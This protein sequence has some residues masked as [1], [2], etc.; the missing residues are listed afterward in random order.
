[1]RR[2][3][4]ADTAGINVD[5]E[6]LAIDDFRVRADRLDSR[7]EQYRA[8]DRISVLLARRDQLVRVDVTLA[9]APGR[10]WRLDVDP[11][12]KDAAVQMRNRWLTPEP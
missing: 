8:G 6:I 12:A 7:L 4:P 10:G 5:D 11:A 1:V 3:A 9:G 2:G